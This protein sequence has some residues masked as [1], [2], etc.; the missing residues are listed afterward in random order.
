MKDEGSF[1][2]VYYEQSSLWGKPPNPYQIRVRADVLNLLPQ[3]VESIL[4]VGCGDGFIT[5]AL[6][7][8]LRVIGL[9]ISMEALRHVQRHHVAGSGSHLPFSMGSFDLVMANDVIEHIPEDSYLLVLDEIA[10]VAKK[11]ILV[12]VPF[13]ENLTGFLTKC[14]ACGEI[15]HIN[16]HHRAFGVV[17]LVKLFERWNPA[18]FAFSGVDLDPVEVFD[19]SLRGFL[20]L[21]TYWEGAVCPQCGAMA[22]TEVDQKTK[23]LV[24]ILAQHLPPDRA[25][26]HPNRSECAVLFERGSGSFDH[27]IGEARKILQ[28]VIKKNG[29]V[30][31]FPADIASSAGKC[32]AEISDPIDQASL[33]ALWLEWKLPERAYRYPNPT[34]FAPDRFILPAWF[35]PDSLEGL[36]PS[37]AM[38][39][40]NKGAE[41]LLKAM[42][43]LF[44]DVPRMQAE[45]EFRK[46]FRGAW[47]SMLE[48]LGI[49]R[50]GP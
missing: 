20:G 12:T 4:D 19:K 25:T 15:Y 47:R 38:W 45:I 13:M 32:I 8:N 33:D 9:D 24:Q 41:L 27:K 43:S 10:R 37:R 17:E 49:A 14:D 11:Y 42:G 36:S 28:L 2:K 1:C 44:E 22:S 23:S 35:S 3:D 34:P 30:S 31:A 26:S 40:G 46:G 5:N 16:H 50:I 39:S 7:D 29:T 48:R 21:M 6:P 18:I